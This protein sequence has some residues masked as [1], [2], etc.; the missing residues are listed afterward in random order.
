MYYSVE[1][2]Q[3]KTKTNKQQKQK[4]QINKHTYRANTE[5]TFFLQVVLF[6]ILVYEGGFQYEF[7]R[8]TNEHV[9]TI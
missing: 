8:L 5:E 3:K 4:Q 9:F 2:R 7:K 6:S 1:R